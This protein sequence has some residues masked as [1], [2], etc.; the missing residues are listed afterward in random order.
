MSPSAY[1]PAPEVTVLVIVRPGSPT[2]EVTVLGGVVIGVGVGLPGVAGGVPVAVAV[3]TTLP[4]VTS[5]G[6]TS[7]VAVQVVVAPALSVPGS[8]IGAQ[9]PS[10]AFGS[11]TVTLLIGRPPVFSTTRL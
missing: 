10:T 5:A 8:A 9:V 2:G 7:W 4:A 6:V 1:G 11:F 3:F